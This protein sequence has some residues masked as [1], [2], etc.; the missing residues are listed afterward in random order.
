MFPI[1]VCGLPPEYCE[2][3]P[4]FEKCKPWLRENFPDLY[5]NLLQEE[6]EGI[7]HYLFCL[8]YVRG[9]R[10]KGLFK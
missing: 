1:L 8:T 2:F 7:T 6:G 10:R 5:P 9:K 4:N 3:G